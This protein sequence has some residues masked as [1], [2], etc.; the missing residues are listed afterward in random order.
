[1][2]VRFLVGDYVGLDIAEGCLRFVLD[3]VVERLDDVFLEPLG[4]RVGVDCG[5]TLGVAVFR[6]GQAEHLHFN[7]GRNQ[8]DY[9]VMYWGITGVVWSAI[10]VQTVSMSAG[11]IPW[12]RRNSFAAFAPSTSKRSVA[13]LCRRVSPMSWN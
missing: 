11:E 1:M 4:A 5:L 7:A 6:I 8:S 12:P 13:L 3:A 9:G 10:A 2:E